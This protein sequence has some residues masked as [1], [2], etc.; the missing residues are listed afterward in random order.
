MYDMERFLKVQESMYEI[1]LTEIKK[2]HKLDIYFSAPL[3]SLEGYFSPSCD[4]NM[5][6][7]V[8][9]DLSNFDTT[10]LTNMKS[11][12]ADCELLESVDF[13]NF[14]GSSIINMNSLFSNC[15]LLKSIDFFLNLW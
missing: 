2:G 3:G 7:V 15:P 12:F 13:Y 10:K 6:Y 11:A 9:V 1:A 4:P 5:K 14:K 8:S